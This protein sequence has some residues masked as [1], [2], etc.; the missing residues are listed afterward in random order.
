ME[1]VM[2]LIVMTKLEN[3]F[4]TFF[5]TFLNKNVE[6]PWYE[7]AVITKTNNQVDLSII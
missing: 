1:H 2:G 7:F 6:K 4:F 3:N 5:S